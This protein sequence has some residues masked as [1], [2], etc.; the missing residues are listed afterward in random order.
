M[1]YA[2]W[3]SWTQS[4]GLLPIILVWLIRTFLYSNGLFKRIEGLEN[5]LGHFSFLHLSGV[6]IS[7]HLLQCQ[8]SRF[9]MVSEMEWL[10]KKNVLF[11]L[12]WLHLVRLGKSGL[13]ISRIIL[14]CMSYGDSRWS[15]WVIEDEEEVTRHIKIALVPFHP[16]LYPGRLGK[17]DLTFWLDMMPEYRHSILQTYASHLYIWFTRFKIGLLGI[18]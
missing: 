17:H 6:D 14:G 2:D 10:I 5:C 9:R 11:Q 1:H 4:I 7:F 8:K 16:S 3:I 12:I 15:K 18:F 13:K